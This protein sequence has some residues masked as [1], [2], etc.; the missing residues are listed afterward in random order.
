MERYTLNLLPL[1]PE[2]GESPSLPSVYKQCIIMI[3]ALYSLV[4]ALP[5]YDLFR[6]L[7]KRYVG[8]AAGLRIG[9]RMSAGENEANEAAKSNRYGKRVE[10]GIG[11]P[12]PYQVG[13]NAHVKSKDEPLTEDVVGSSTTSTFSFAPVHT[14]IG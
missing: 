8:Y 7:R 2:F 6:N 11:R 9:C 10:I 5:I 12:F 1:P 4:R 13:I 14:P 3:R